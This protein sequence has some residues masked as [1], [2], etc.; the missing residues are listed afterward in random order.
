[1]KRKKLAALLLISSLTAGSALTAFA[2]PADGTV[3]SS[4][5]AEEAEVSGEGAGE[6]TE[7]GDTPVEDPNQN[8]SAEEIGENTDPENTTPSVPGTETNNENGNSGTETGTDPIPSNS[9]NSGGTA[10]PEDPEINDAANQAANESQAPQQ[11]TG[12]PGVAAP[13]LSWVSPDGIIA[14]SAVILEE[15]ESDETLSSAVRR[16]YRKIDG[17]IAFAKA[18]D[19]KIYEEGSTEAREVGTIAA[20]GLLHVLKVKGSYLYVESMNVRGYVLRSSVIYGPKAETLAEGRDLTEA[21]AAKALVKL[22]DNRA[23][24]DY[25]VTVY[26]FQEQAGDKVIRYAK[27]HLDSVYRT[28]GTSW[29]TGIDNNG[30]VHAVY[31]FFDLISEEENTAIEQSLQQVKEAVSV[32]TAASADTGE[33]AT[34]AALTEE[35]SGSAAVSEAA[36]EETA[37]AEGAAYQSFG[38]AVTDLANAQAGDLFI[39]DPNEICLYTGADTVL[40]CTEEE[41]GVTEKSIHDVLIVSMRRPNYENQVEEAEAES[42]EAQDENVLIG[43][44]IEEQ[45]WNYLTKNIGLSE[46]AAAGAMG[47]IKAECGFKPGNLENWVNALMN[48]TDEQFTAACDTGVYTYSQF[49]DDKYT[50]PTSGNG[51]QWGYGLIG[52][53][54]RSAKAVLW[55]NTIAKGRSLSDLRGQLD[56]VAQIYGEKLFWIS[57]ASVDQAAADWFY[58]V[59]MGNPLGGT[60]GYG[61]EYTIPSRQAYAAEYYAMFH[62]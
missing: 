29:T 57:S 7:S 13:D 14:S 1:M 28:D 39:L 38:E 41:Q 50:F 33:T 42:E 6:S 43:A 53:T 9:D 25:Q 56:A 19:T 47:N 51:S 36:Q 32:T 35:T 4:S 60:N 30:F 17:S 45:C 59:G 8:G 48:C 44:T 5:A 24:D 22:K 55:A 61:Y 23:A 31:D 12:R 20:N 54:S 62:S 49:M 10:A 52:F 21:P 40:I 15:D 16:D 11:T 27:E 34:A 58:Y 2:D 3:S 37:D 46:T 26:Q 18:D